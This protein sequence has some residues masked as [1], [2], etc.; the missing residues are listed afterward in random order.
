[1]LEILSPGDILTLAVKLIGSCQVII[2]AAHVTILLLLLVLT[3]YFSHMK[4]NII[5]PFPHQGGTVTIGIH[6]L[7]VCK[8]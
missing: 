5:I 2:K 3:G 4:T 1:M 6:L 7:L 8:A